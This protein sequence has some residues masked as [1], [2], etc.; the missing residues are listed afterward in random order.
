MEKW[1]IKQI[2]DK[3]KI[4]YG[5]KEYWEKER[6]SKFHRNARQEEEH[7]LKTS[8]G[9]I[10]LWSS[11]QKVE[12]PLLLMLTD[13]EKNINYFHDGNSWKWETKF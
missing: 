1:L 7:I 2:L 13:K 9:I 6:K 4:E 11:T 5:T 12:M 3:N 10:A 8:E